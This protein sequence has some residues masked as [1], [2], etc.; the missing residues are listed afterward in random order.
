MDR[1]RR[2]G[3]EETRRKG[4]LVGYEQNGGRG[5]VTLPSTKSNRPTKGGVFFGACM[6][7]AGEG[8]GGQRRHQGGREETPGRMGEDTGRMEDLLEWP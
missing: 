1:D 8:C 6:G 7:W 4:L 5:R 3:R 2:E